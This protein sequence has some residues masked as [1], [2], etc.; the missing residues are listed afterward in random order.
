MRPARAALTLG[1]AL[2][3][4]VNSPASHTAPAS[5]EEI[6][7]G[8][9]L[10]QGGMSQVWAATT[11]AGTPVAVKVSNPGSASPAVARQLVRREY[12]FLHELSHRNIVSV[13]GLIEMDTELGIVMEYVGGGDLVSLAGSPPR[14]WLA[15][16]ARV[17]GALEYL[18]A[19]GVVHRDIKARNILLR[20]GDEPCLIDFSLAAAVGARSPRGG[21][22][23]AYQSANQRRGGPAAVGDDLYAFAA[24]I[25][26]LWTG[27]LPFGRHPSPETLARSG[28]LRA[29]LESRGAEGLNPL[30]ELV[31]GTLSSRKKGPCGG[32]GP[33][34]DALELAVNG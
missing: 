20:Q 9:R 24:L 27:A 8:E 25:Y 16:A 34:L 22:T 21:G 33:F 18:H 23:A 17:A 5:L 10:G 31:S 15:L 30:A 1:R 7:L 13:L 28:E 32:I 11:A 12:G 4:F 26:E 6:R 2:F 3:G 14:H 19:S 29:M